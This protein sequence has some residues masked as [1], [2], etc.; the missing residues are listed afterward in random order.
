MNSKEYRDT[1]LTYV[2]KLGQIDNLED[3]LIKSK[4]EPDKLKQEIAE[5]KKEV[6]KL[7]EKI[8]NHKIKK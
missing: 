4:G 2:N 5:L 8:D 3:E 6:T 7:K 1:V